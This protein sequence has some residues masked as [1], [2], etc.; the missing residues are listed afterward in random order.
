MVIQVKELY[1]LYHKDMGVKWRNLGQQRYELW[2]K[3]G[4]FSGEELASPRDRGTYLYLVGNYHK[5]FEGITPVVS[6]ARHTQGVEWDE[7]IGIVSGTKRREKIH[8]C[9]QAYAARIARERKLTLVDHTL[10]VLR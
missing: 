2:S 9:V 4:L 5:S 3:E 6:I 8:A 1:L 10:S 7:I